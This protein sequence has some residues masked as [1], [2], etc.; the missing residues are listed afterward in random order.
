MDRLLY[1]KKE[2]KNELHFQVFHI[3]AQRSNGLSIRSL[4]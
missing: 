2:D 3:V 1:R 4:I